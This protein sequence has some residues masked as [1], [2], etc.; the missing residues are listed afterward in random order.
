M[1]VDPKLCDHYARECIAM[2][3]RSANPEHQRTLTELAQS[4]VGLARQLARAQPII[5]AYLPS[6][7]R[8]GAKRGPEGDIAPL[9]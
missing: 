6:S 1:P 9:Q 3:Q 8:S 2:A 7:A 5:D 4:W